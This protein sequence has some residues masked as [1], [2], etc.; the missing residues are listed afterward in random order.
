MLIWIAAGL[1]LITGYD[2]LRTGLRHMAEDAPTPERPEVK[3]RY[4][5]WM[6]RTVGLAEEEVTPPA[7]VGTVGDLVVW[8]RTPQSRP[9]RGAG[10]GRCLR[11]RR[12]PAHRDRSTC[13]S[14]VP[15]RSRSFRPSPAAEPT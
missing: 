5:A 13:R 2:Y 9:C 4:F 12:R 6:K 10:R 15:A 3:I 7:E 11:R 8:L 1:T 14:P